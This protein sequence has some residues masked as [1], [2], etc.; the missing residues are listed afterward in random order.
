MRSV[1]RMMAAGGTMP[2]GVMDDEELI[3]SALADS[4]PRPVR[5]GLVRRKRRVRLV[6]PSG[7]GFA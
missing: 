4:G 1:A 3:Q 5:P 6:N 7:K 2:E